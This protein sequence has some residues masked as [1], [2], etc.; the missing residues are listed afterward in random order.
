MLNDWLLLE[1]S[2]RKAAKDEKQL[3][4]KSYSCCTSGKTLVLSHNSPHYAGRT[5]MHCQV[6]VSPF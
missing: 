4:Y 5:E 1:T 2:F 6:E 3:F